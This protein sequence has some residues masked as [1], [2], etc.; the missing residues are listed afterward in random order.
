MPYSKGSVAVSWGET[1]PI[2]PTVLQS[3]PSVTTGMEGSILLLT[4]LFS[5]S[6]SLRKTNKLVRSAI[7]SKNQGMPGL[8][9]KQHNPG[10][11]CEKPKQRNEGKKV[12]VDC[13][14]E[15]FAEMIP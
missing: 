2:L 13:C 9:K 5:H 12:L 3:V 14:I 8:C 4:V 11:F 15:G 1:P 6:S 10:D 7:K